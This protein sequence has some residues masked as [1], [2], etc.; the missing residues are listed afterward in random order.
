M[1]TGSYFYWLNYSKGLLLVKDSCKN[2]WQ[3]T[4]LN[5]KKIYSKQ[6]FYE[7]KPVAEP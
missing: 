2:T 4:E 1:P 3:K 6:H 7:R 5:I